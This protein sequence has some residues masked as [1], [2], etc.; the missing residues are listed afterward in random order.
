MEKYRLKIQMVSSIVV[1]V[2]LSFLVN[3]SKRTTEHI[4]KVY[5]AEG[6]N[7]AVLYD[8]DTK[9]AQVLILDS[10]SVF[11][12][13]SASQNNEWVELSKMPAD[14]DEAH[15]VNEEK[16]LM[17]VPQKRIICNPNYGKDAYLIGI[18][19]TN[20][21]ESVLWDVDDRIDSI[22]IAKLEKTYLGHNKDCN[23]N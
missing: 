16:L 20:N 19:L 23:C 6:K 10:G 3:C 12:V 13:L 4:E 9:K 21:I 22:P 1:T 15:G 7:T 18:D 17:N 14:P 11:F 8:T 2:S 5:I